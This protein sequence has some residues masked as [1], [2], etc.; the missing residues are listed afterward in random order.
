MRTIL[1]CDLNNFY[2]SVECVLNPEIANYPVAVCGSVEKRSGIVLAKNE[3]A[4]SMGVV[5]AEAIWQAKQKCHNLLIIPPHFDAYEEYSKKVHEIYTRYTDRVEAFGIDECWLDVTGSTRLFGSGEEIAYKI[6]EAVKTEIGLKIS[7]GVSFNKVFAKLGSDMKKP[8]AITSIPYEKF[9][10][11]VWHLPCSDMIGI[12]KATNSILKKYSIYSLG[13]LANCEC[14]FIKR[15]LGVCGVHIWKHANGLDDSLVTTTDYTREIKSCG[16]SA[17]L[18]HDLLTPDQVWNV[19]LRLS[20]NV[21]ERLRKHN[22][23]ANGVQISVK[24]PDLH[25]C[26]FQMQLN[27]PI[28]SSLVLCK[29]GFELF[30]DNFHW[31]DNVRAIGIRA[32]NLSPSTIDRQFCMLDD[33]IRI[34]KLEKLEVVRDN[35][36]DKYGA[37]V[38]VPLSF[39]K[40][41]FKNIDNTLS[42]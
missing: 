3:L 12:G 6:K 16:N 7:V 39:K 33:Y 28:T 35:L 19:M 31:Q 10:E 24:T 30:M 15:I 37:N 22:V 29:A 38:V 27:T 34:E 2:A 21:S 32:I 26:E 5:T 4:K 42:K 14:D 18:P 17:T 13:D 9:K 11:M 36:K 25:K 20:N 8:D 23:Y 41:I 40:Q 1:H